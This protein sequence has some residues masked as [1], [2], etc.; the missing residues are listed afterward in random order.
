M[1]VLL[2]G[3]SGYA[4]FAAA[5]RRAGGCVTGLVRDPHSAWPQ[6][7]RRQQVRVLAGDLRRPATYRAALTTCYVCLTAALDYQDAVGTDLLLL[8]MLRGLPA[9]LVSPARGLSKAKRAG[10]R[11]WANPAGAGRGCTWPTW[12]MRTAAL[13]RLPHYTRRFFA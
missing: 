1:D 11:T 13:S 10:W 7:L 2:L 4:G 5:L 9:A 12:P 3:A 8:E 6:A